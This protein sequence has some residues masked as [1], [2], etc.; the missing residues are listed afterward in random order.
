MLTRLKSPE[1]AARW[2]T[3]WCTGT[4]RTDSR[5]VMPGDAFIAWPGYARDGREY[6]AAALA[7]GAATCLVEDADVDRFGFTDARVASL[8]GLKARTGEI[9]ATFFGNPTD[10]LDVIAVTGTNGKTSSAW[11]IAQASA[12]LN[13]RCGVVG[14]LGIGEPPKLDYNGLTTPD[15]VLLQAAFARMQQDD[16]AACAIEASSIGIVEK[17]LAGTA[18]RVAVFTNFTQDHLDYHGDMDA[19]WVAKRALFGFPG[20]R[21]AVV[22]LDDAKGAGLAA[23]LSA[24]DVW[25][26]GVQRQDARLT[27]RGLHYTGEGLAFTLHEG[28]DAVPLQTGLIGDYN[29]ANLLGVAG[30]LRAQ[31]H[32]L[33]DVARALAR[34]TPVPGRMQRVGNGRELPQVVV[35]YAHTPDALDKA[36]S[37][38]QG[39]ATA[40][41]GELVCV[42]GCGGDRDRGK[43]PQMGAIAARLAGRVVVTTDNPRTEAAAQILADITAAAPAATVIE[44]R[45]E[46]IR[47]AIAE[48]GARDIVLIA[49]KGHEDYQEV[50]GVRRP[51]SD[52]AEA[53]TAL[54]ERAG[55]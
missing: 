24:L 14:T 48:A 44:A 13:K 7:A 42:F 39:L 12:V 37:A 27:A 22:N 51:F 34:V 41:G 20:L 45:E 8:P 29:A 40:R 54:L 10:K 26:T 3:E 6:V 21:A 46:A 32:S 35:D 19:Y 9:A 55:L 17:R 47:G 38:L 33:A 4:L 43:R 28:A 11:W 16:F 53:R 2:L 25:T 31:G 50:M 49:G 15:P 23:E 1:A 36:L 5:Q 18:V 30:A 52:V